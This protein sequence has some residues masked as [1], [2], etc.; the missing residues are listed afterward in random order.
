VNERVLDII[1]SKPWLREFPLT[2]RVLAADSGRIVR[3]H[4]Q[5]RKLL[6]PMNAGS[7]PWFVSNDGDASISGVPGTSSA[8]DIE[9][10][11]NGDILPTGRVLDQIVLD[12]NQVWIYSAHAYS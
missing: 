4:V 1:Y 9:N 5:V 2:V 3:A 6:G 11:L 10:P 12:G 8:V 7:P